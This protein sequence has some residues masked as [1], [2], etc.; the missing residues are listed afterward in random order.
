MH[1]TFT[2]EF[3]ILC[4]FFSGKAPPSASMFFSR[5]SGPL[6]LARHA[7]CPRWEWR[8]DRACNVDCVLVFDLPVKRIS[9]RLGAGCPFPLNPFSYPKTG[10]SGKQEERR[11]MGNQDHRKAEDTKK[12]SGSF[13]VSP[14]LTIRQSNRD[15]VAFEEGTH[16]RATG[17]G[18]GLSR[19][20]Y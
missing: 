5:K 12:Q 11:F 4:R 6:L 20:K 14:S 7:C 10:T 13:N 19:D 9:M 8:F 3:C 16:C 18:G 17:G 2:I 1:R 15:A